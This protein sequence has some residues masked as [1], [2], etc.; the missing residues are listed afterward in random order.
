MPPVLTFDYQILYRETWLKA[1]H[2]FSI[3]TTASLPLPSSGFGHNS[4]CMTV[5]TRMVVALTAYHKRR[6][7]LRDLKTIK[8]NFSPV[9]DLYCEICTRRWM[10]KLGAIEALVASLPAFSRIRLPF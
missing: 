3:E 1:Y 2:Q 4:N 8:A 6:T 5:N 9:Y 7:R 10:Q